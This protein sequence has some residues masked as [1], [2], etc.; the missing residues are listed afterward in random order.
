MQSD[1]GVG[2]R[3]AAGLR[4]ALRVADLLAGGP[5]TRGAEEDGAAGARPEPPDRHGAARLLSPNG[6]APEPAAWHAAWADVLAEESARRGRAGLGW[7]LT[8]LASG[9]F[10]AVDV[11]EIGCER[12]RLSRLACAPDG[13][14]PR[15]VRLAESSWTELAPAAAALPRERSGRL[16]LLAGA[17]HDTTAGSGTGNGTSNSAAHAAANGTGTGT[18]PHAAL[19]TAL[20]AGL[21]AFLR[22]AYRDET[23]PLVLAV[24]AAGWRPLERAAEAVRAGAGALLCL[25]LPAHW[26]MAP[27]DLTAELP[28]HTTVWLAAAQVDGGSG[29]VGLVRRPLF[30]AG[31]RAG[32]RAAAGPVVHV[33]VGAP[34]PG[35]TTGESVAAVVCAGPEEPAARW[36]PLRLDRLALPPGSRTTLRYSLHTG[37]RVELRCEGHHETE[38]AAWPALAAGT[39]RRLARPR[40]VDLLV[41][42]EIAGP[43]GDGGTAVE[44]RMQEAV[45][46]VAAVREAVGD[47]DVLRVGL[48]GYRDHDP[49]HRPHDH[50]PVVHRVG[51][52]PAGDAARVLAS[53][54]PH[55]LR[56]DFATGLE[57]VPVELSAWRPL[58]RADS[59]RVLLTVGSRPP[60]PHV[61]P[62]RVL[63]RGAPVRICPDRLDWQAG[64][65]AARHHEDIAC[66]A[67]VD[68]PA[69]MDE[70][71]GE[72]HLAR[73]ADHAWDTFGAEGRFSAGHDPWL[74][75][76]AVA[77]PALCPPHGGAPIRLVVADGAAGDWQHAV[78]G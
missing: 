42:V 46:V 19:H 24:R 53:W 1:N 71:Q 43:R 56:H 44:E 4:A 49:L 57:H 65:E 59:H 61:R 52:C 78:A 8:R 62:P 75:A 50:D 40:P 54:R 20:C 64:L 72:P 28:L 26:P 12:L 22:T 38:S 76:S 51:L 66:V 5:V 37:H 32:G 6:S 27:D 70:L 74:I 10:P 18:A 3:A 63:R 67:V 68:E 39:A 29:T 45:D 15:T 69:W 41:A 13:T 2:P 17:G 77:A 33:P 7:V 58:W 14:G 31:T 47:E 16:L 55:P 34:P 30:P 60:Y 36:R 21:G 9:A 35:A 73:W 23:V 48:I 25:R 11:L